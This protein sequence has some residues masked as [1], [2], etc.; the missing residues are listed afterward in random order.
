MSRSLYLLALYITEHEGSAPVSSG[1]VAERTDRTAGTV[2]EAFHDLAATKLVEYE[3]HEG[4]ALTDAGYDR[5]Q[6]LHETYVTLSWF[7]RDVLELPEYE[8]E[9]MEMAGAVSPTVARRLAATLL[10]EP[11]QNGGE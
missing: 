6:Q 1:P 8:Q 2:T 10:E 5:A 9:A 11:S 3:P 4:A 7:F